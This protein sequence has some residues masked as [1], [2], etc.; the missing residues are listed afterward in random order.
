VDKLIGAVPNDLAGLLPLRDS[1]YNSA[2]RVEKLE[3]PV[4]NL[5]IV[6]RPTNSIKPEP[7]NARTHSKKQ[8]PEIAASIRQFGFANPHGWLAQ[9]ATG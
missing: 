1:S 5:T 8:V 4:L 6:Y 2:M 3:S 7:R 9:T